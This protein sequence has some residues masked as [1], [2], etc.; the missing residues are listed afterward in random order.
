MSKLGHVGQEHAPCFAHDDAEKSR[1]TG[2]SGKTIWYLHASKF[3][4]GA[5]HLFYAYPVAP[6]FF[7]VTLFYELIQ[8]VCRA[9]CL[10]MEQAYP[11]SRKKWFK[12][13]KIKQEKKKRIGTESCWRVEMTASDFPPHRSLFWNLSLFLSSTAAHWR[14]RRAAGAS[15]FRE[16]GCYSASGGRCGSHGFR[17]ADES[18]EIFAGLNSNSVSSP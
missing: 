10:S 1:W 11:K 9:A 5:R 13:K 12:I 6:D 7:S 8:V 15:G 4:D 3:P 16:L 14:T 18:F 2:V 17:H